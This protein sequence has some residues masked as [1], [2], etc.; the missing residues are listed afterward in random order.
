MLAGRAA[1]EVSSRQENGRTPVGLAIE[2]EIGA[3]GPILR[4]APVEEEKV[5]VTG[6]LDSLEELLG[7]NLIGV[8]IDSV[9]RGPGSGDRTKGVHS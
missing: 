3:R 8:D 2:D 9:E 1:A 5:A 7:D 4:E 6:F